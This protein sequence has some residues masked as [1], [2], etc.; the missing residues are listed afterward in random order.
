VHFVVGRRGRGRFDPRGSNSLLSRMKHNMEDRLLVSWCA[1]NPN[2]TPAQITVMQEA[3]KEMLKPRKLED[4]VGKVGVDGK[5][6][7]RRR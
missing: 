1:A 3:I 7:W 2:A 6:Y 4:L 5:V